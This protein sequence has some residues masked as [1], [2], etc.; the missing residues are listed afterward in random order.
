MKVGD[1]V[2]VWPAGSREISHRTEGIIVGFN[3]KGYGG[4]EFVHVL[5]EGE[6]F[7]FMDFDVKV[8]NPRKKG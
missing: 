3:Q 4:K 6:V 2:Y 8:I 7:V 1:L 5:C